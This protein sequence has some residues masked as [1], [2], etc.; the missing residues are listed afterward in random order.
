MVIE[1]GL[2][3]RSPVATSQGLLRMR[4]RASERSTVEHMREP[5]SLREEVDAVLSGRYSMVTGYSI[6]YASNAH[7]V[8]PSWLHLRQA[9]I[10]SRVCRVPRRGDWRG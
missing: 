4:R 8:F 1:T 3:P 9:R 7:I 10:S 6:P 2:Q 5:S